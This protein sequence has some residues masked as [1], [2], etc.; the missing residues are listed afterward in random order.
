M[1]TKGKRRVA[2]KNKG[3]KK[4]PN[5]KQLSRRIKKLEHSEELKYDDDYDAATVYNN[6][7]FLLLNNIGQ[8]DDY[9]QRIG[10]EIVSKFLNIKF[11]IGRTASIDAITYR[12]MVFWD[13]QANGAAPTLYTSTSLTTGLLDNSLVSIPSMVPHNYRTKDR[14]HILFDKTYVNNAES[15]ATIKWMQI[16]KNF[17]LGGAKVKYGTSGNSIAAIASRALYFFCMA[18]TSSATDTTDFR[19]ATRFWFTDA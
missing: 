9:N 15:S 3:K 18:H 14:Y 19:V 17:K 4:V 5:N 12:V 8:G 10:E 2:K 13:L 1:S 7:S 11:R 16:N 6:S